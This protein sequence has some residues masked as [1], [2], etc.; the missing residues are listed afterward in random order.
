MVCS[1]D[2]TRLR[3][4]FLVRF[5]AVR[6]FVGFD[7]GLGGWVIGRVRKEGGIVARARVGITNPRVRDASSLVVLRG[8]MVTDGRAKEWAVGWAF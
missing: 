6:A 7:L 1:L 5:K 8:K 2:L 3:F 4:D